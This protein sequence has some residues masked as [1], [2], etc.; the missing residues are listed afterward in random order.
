MAGGTGSIGRLR[1]E[2]WSAAAKVKNKT[3]GEEENQNL[4]P[5]QLCAH[6][7]LT[8]PISSYTAKAGLKAVL[9]GTPEG[10]PLQTGRVQPLWNRSS[11]WLFDFLPLGS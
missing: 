10:V 3:A 11:S 9:H 7:G 5:P 4:A 1:G 2:P 6:S 8:A